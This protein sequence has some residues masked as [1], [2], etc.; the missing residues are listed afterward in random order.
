MTQF[1]PPAHRL[2]FA[3]WPGA[4]ERTALLAWQAALQP[5]CGGRPQAPLMLHATL[6]FLGAVA[7]E[8][9]QALQF[10]AQEISCSGFMLQLNV[11][12]YWGHNHLV[13]AAPAQVPPAMLQLVDALQRRLQQ[14]HFSFERRSYKPH[15]SLLRHAQWRDSPLPLQPAVSWDVRDFV[16]VQSVSEGQGVRYDIL[17]RF[18]LLA[19]AA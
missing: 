10:A 9:M 17:A 6:V 13:Y 16:L 18:P 7:E 1:T 19:P 15:V 2:F 5:L 8:R 12:R 4:T 3:L 14:H 11:A